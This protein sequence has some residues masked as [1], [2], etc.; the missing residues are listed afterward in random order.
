[1]ASAIADLRK[2]YSSRSLSEDGVERS[3][4]DQFKYW[5]QEAIDAEL[6]EPT[7]MV[8]ATSTRSGKPSARVVLL[9]GI[10]ERGFVFYTNYESRKAEELKE[11]PHAALLFYWGALER[12]VRIE[13]VIEKTTHTESEEYF[14]TRPL[15]SRIG[16]WASKQSS[17]IESR[18]AL[19]EK[20]DELHAQ[21]ANQ[22]IPLPPFWGGFRLTPVTFEFWQGRENRLHDRIRY[23]KQDGS[24]V[25]E[26][27]SP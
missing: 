18:S 7:A 11:N 20:F 14:T 16:A 13:G 25:I 6:L 23:R 17:V 15:E 24:W 22:A 10:D 26:R 4:F 1:M 2:K 21:F 19:Q 5:M 12:Q 27:L 3:P 8:L 9:K